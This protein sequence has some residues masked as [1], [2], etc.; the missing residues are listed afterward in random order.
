MIKHY[1]FLISCTILRFFTDLWFTIGYSKYLFNCEICYIDLNA[2]VDYVGIF[3]R[4]LEGLLTFYLA[5]FVILRI[6]KG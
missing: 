3:D 2:G 1:S 6:Y 5:I 4:L